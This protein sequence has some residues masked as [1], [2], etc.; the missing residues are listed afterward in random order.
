LFQGFPDTSKAAIDY[1]PDAYFGIVGLLM[2]LS[3]R[4]IFLN[5]WRKALMDFNA[6]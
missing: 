5:I 6:A 2:H 4:F 3:D 1:R